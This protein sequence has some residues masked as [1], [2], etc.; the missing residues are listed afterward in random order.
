MSNVAGT[1][2]NVLELSLNLVGIKCV[3]S[4]TASVRVT[5]QDG[6]EQEGMWHLAA[7]A[8]QGD[9]EH[10]ANGHFE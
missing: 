7:V 4:D 6:I 1:T 8:E 2:R 5:S 10:G 3:L 9:L